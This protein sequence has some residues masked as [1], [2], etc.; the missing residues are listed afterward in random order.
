ML[1]FNDNQLGHFQ[2]RKGH[3]V[4]KRTLSLLCVLVGLFLFIRFGLSGRD[5]NRISGQEEAAQVDQELFGISPSLVLEQLSLST[6]RDQ[7]CRESARVQEAREEDAG[8]SSRADNMSLEARQKRCNAFT[9]IIDLTF[10]AV[11]AI[12]RAG[13]VPEELYSFFLMFP[14][15]GRVDTWSSITATPYQ[16]LEQCLRARA[17]AQEV[18][19]DTLECRPWKDPWP[20]SREDR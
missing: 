3:L 7:E 8:S 14:E 17:A 6:K 15:P 4:V 2:C 16:T 10:Q 9:R 11:H 20:N 5:E 18:Q 13:A 19:I 1:A 12:K